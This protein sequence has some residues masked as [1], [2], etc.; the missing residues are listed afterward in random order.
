MTG[1]PYPELVERLRRAELLT[2]QQWDEEPTLTGPFET[3][4]AYA[5]ALVKRGWL[6]SFQAFFFLKDNR[7][8]LVRDGYRRLEPMGTGGQGELFRALQVTLTRPG[9]LKRLRMDSGADPDALGRLKRE[10]L[11][12]A[13]L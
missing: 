12:V 10:A 6:T 5:D 1:P 2:P 4:A 13:R 9:A 11:A 3:P 8:D 7:D